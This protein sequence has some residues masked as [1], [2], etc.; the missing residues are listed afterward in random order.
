VTTVEQAAQKTRHKADTGSGW[1]EW[2]ARIGLAAKGISFAILGI[3]A[4]KLAL[5]DGGRAT[6]REGALAAISHE[7][8]GKLLLIALAA[9]FACY[10]LW[11]VVQAFAERDTEGDAEGWAKKWGKRAGYLGRAAIYAG[12]SWVTVKIIIGSPR[13]GSQNEEARKTTSEVLDWPAGRWLIGALGLVIAGAGIWNAYTSFSTRFEDR[14]QSMGKGIRRW[15]T[16]IGVAGYFARG[17]V[18]FMVGVFITK[19]AVEYDPKEAIGLD[20]ALQKL[21]HQTYGD[22][23]LGATAAGLLAYGLVCLIDARYRDISAN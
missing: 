21:A 2:L 17:V 11:R 13:G 10:A 8:A 3:L 1:Y 14:W 15:G 7:W 19:A 12:L 22:W 5:G 20:G 18:F 16:G 9:G 6:S 4:L 23:L